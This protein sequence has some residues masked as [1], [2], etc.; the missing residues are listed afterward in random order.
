MGRRVFV[1]LALLTTGSCTRD[2][3]VAPSIPDVNAA[4]GIQA[5]FSASTGRLIVL[6]G[7]PG[8]VESGAIAVNDAGYVA[9]YTRDV[10][11]GCAHIVLWDPSGTPVDLGR[12]GV[13]MGLNNANQVAGI[14]DD[15]PS[16]GVSRAFLWS[17]G[18]GFL[19]LGSLAGTFSTAHAISEN[20]SVVGTTAV[21][22]GAGSSAFLYTPGTGMQDLSVL[23]GT[24]LYSA[25]SVN[26]RGDVLADIPNVG[27]AVWNQ[28]TGF[29]VVPP[30][31]AGR[32]QSGNGFAI[33]ERGWVVGVDASQNGRSHAFLW[34]PGSSPVDLGVLW[35]DPVNERSTPYGLTENGIVVGES[36]TSI[37]PGENRAFSWSRNRGMQALPHIGS[38]CVALDIN[39]TGR[40]AVGWCRLSSGTVQAVKWI[41]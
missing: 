9:G 7:P 21:R 32:P 5:E 1:V 11:G 26:S 3:P 28:A 4:S 27:A 41:R 20:G 18:T 33:N 14:L 25:R 34:V 17:S 37:S 12:C 39:P 8:T 36:L 19:D 31:V 30:L 40:L 2:Q 24:Q 15:T 23:T 38:G 6:A 16:P 22:Y 13:A 10:P 35:I 29:R